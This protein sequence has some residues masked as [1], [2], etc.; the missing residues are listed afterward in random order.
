MILTR[1][2]HYLTIPWISPS[3]GTT[4]DKYIIEI[5]VWNG[6]KASVPA[7]TNYQIENKNPLERTGSSDVNI[8]NYINDFLDYSLESD[9]TTNVI[10]S[11]SAVWVKTQVIYYIGGVAQ[12]PEFVTT[13]LA[14]K[15]Y[16]YGIEGKNTTIPANNV[17]SSVNS[18]RVSKNSNYTIPVKVD[19]SVSTDFTVISYPDN[20]INKSFTITATTNSHELIKNIFIKCSE[21]GTDKSIEITKDSE[22]IKEL[23]VK[24]ENKYT[25]VD[26][27]FLNKYGQ[28]DTLVFFKDSLES[29][30]TESKEF[31]TNIGQAADGVHQFETYEKNGNTEYK[32]NSGWVKES[33]NEIFKQ[34]FLSKKIWHFKDEVFIPLNL[35]SNNLQY[36]TKKRDKLINYEVN[37]KYA[38]NEVNDI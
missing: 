17:L 29:L 31:Q 6:L 26:I 30:K 16:G 2:P 19:E 3:S 27:Y 24:E 28:L 32:I 8:S 13:D 11:N 22:V 21:I 25:P 35:K 5:Y 36:Q 4:P 10:N 1:S 7:S 23:I 34:L 18:V 33:N 38:F 20:N 14:I 15:G 37:F 12:S 9:T